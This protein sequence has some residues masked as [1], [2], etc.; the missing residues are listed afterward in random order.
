MKFENMKE[1]AVLAETHN[2]L[3]AAEQLY[4]SQATL[5]RHIKAMEE[6]LGAALFD[7]STRRVELTSLGVMLLPYA[8]RAIKLQEEYEG[9]IAKELKIK[10]E[11]LV[12]GAFKRWN[13]YDIP[14]ILVNF[15]IED[16]RARI[17]LR[18]MPSKDLLEMV[19]KGEC[20]FAFA[21]ELTGK[22][23][24]GL[25]RI[26]YFEDILTVYLPKG[27]PLSGCESVTMEQLKD[28]NFLLP[29]GNTFAHD[30]CLELCHRAGFEPKYVFKGINGTDIY[31]LIQKGLGIA[32]LIMPFGVPIKAPGLVNVELD[33]DFHTYV[34]LIY[35]DR[36][37]SPMERRFLEFFQNYL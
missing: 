22:S 23:E 30:I 7:R 37:L 15:Q 33:T 3:E 25:I 26:P 18:T 36:V 14:D 5:S 19:R 10:E 11:T 29:E 27:H 28:E 24:A 1:F 34:N 9:A 2:Y 6:E 21:R 32:V 13:D 4:I 17:D 35:E 16:R 12:I 8:R 31:N 20:Q